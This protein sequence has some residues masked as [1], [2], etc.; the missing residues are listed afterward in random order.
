MLLLGSLPSGR[1]W[2][3]AKACS[4]AQGLWGGKWGPE[5]QQ[6]AREWGASAQQVCPPSCQRW[7]ELRKAW[8]S[9]Q[10]SEDIWKR[11][12]WTAL[13]HGFGL[14]AAAP[15]SCHDLGAFSA[16]Q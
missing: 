10:G 5:V 16:C 2:S 7:G 13:R 6:R 8:L 15:S 11:H 14:R 12:L 9:L 4:T 1:A 3:L